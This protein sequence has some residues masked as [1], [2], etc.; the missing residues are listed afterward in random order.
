MQLLGQLQG[1]LLIMTDSS[2]RKP[3]VTDLEKQVGNALRDTQMAQGE[4]RQFQQTITALRDKLEDLRHE[5]DAEIQSIKAQN[6]SNIS[7]YKLS[8]QALRDEL[9]NMKLNSE[10]SLQSLRAE[11]LSEMKELRETAISLRA[12]LEDN[13][14]THQ[15]KVQDLTR[16][17]HEEKSQLQNTIANLREKLEHLT[18]RGA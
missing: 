6:E 7:Q 5:K 17:M 13:A 11:S 8:I 9:E 1:F 14:F 3:S 4:N 16:E 10:T 12:A 15:T 2:T 18:S